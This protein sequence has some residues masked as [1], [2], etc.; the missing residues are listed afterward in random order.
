MDDEPMYG[1]DAPSVIPGLS[2]RDFLGYCAKLAGLLALSET[3]APRIAA[4]VEEAAARP[5]L[6]WSDFQM[7]TGCTVSLVQ[8]VS[9]GPAELILKVLSLD[10]QET[11]MAAAGD[12]AE[13]SFKDAVAKGDFFYVV[14]GAIPTKVPTAM[15]VA[16]KNA[17]DIAKEAAAKAKAIIAIGNCATYGG[18]QAAAPNPTGALGVTDFFKKEGIDKPVINIPTCPGNADMMIATLV[19]FLLLGKLPD[20]D[21]VG[22]PVF[23]YGE[24]IHDNCERRGHFEKGEFV[25]RFGTPEEALGYCLFKVGCKGPDTYAPCSKLRWNNRMS[26]CVGVAPCIGCA[27]PG[28]W[29]K[30]APY[31][32]RMPGVAFAGLAGLKADTVGWVMGGA[33][34]LGLGAHFVGQAAT[35]RLGKGGPPEDEG[36]V[37]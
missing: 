2:R 36:T 10:Y 11:I 35:G 26:W 7:C 8:N 4:A 5:S 29:D 33:A 22:R 28:F 14:E 12:A 17:V 24:T 21:A 1:Q 27:E 23:L 18:I 9:P 13:K 34:A 25:E 3:A 20:L 32:D 19:H 31:Y 15:T 30:F 16:G 6:V 37:R